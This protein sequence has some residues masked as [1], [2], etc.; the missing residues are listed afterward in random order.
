MGRL[1]S[2]IPLIQTFRG[3][4]MIG[5]LFLLWALMSI[6]AYFL[7]LAVERIRTQV[8][9]ERTSLER[10]IDAARVARYA[11][12][13]TRTKALTIDP[14]LYGRWEFLTRT[15]QNTC[16]ALS[17]PVR[18]WARDFDAVT[19]ETKLASSTASK[20]LAAASDLVIPLREDNVSIDAAARG[21]R[22]VAW[23]TVLFGV[24]G[25]I[26]L[27]S[28]NTGMLSQI[29]LE[30]GIVPANLRFLGLS[31]HFVFALLLTVVEAGIGFMHAVTKST[32][33]HRLSLS[34]VLAVVGGFAIA[35]V[36]GF[37]YSRI[38]AQ[39]E[40][41]DRLSRL[42]VFG[43]NFTSEEIFFLW[44]L[45]LVLTLFGFGSVVGG[46]ILTIARTKATSI[47]HVR[48]V[49]TAAA[50][51]A[52]SVERA[53]ERLIAYSAQW[54]NLDSPEAPPVC[55]QAAQNIRDLLARSPEWAS[56]ETVRLGSHDVTAL[57]VR[58]SVCLG[59]AAGASLLMALV[60]SVL[61][62]SAVPA[63]SRLVSWAA[64]FGL[65]AACVAVGFLLR[66][67]DAFEFTGHGRVLKEHSMSTLAVLIVVGALILGWG[68]YGVV[69]GWL[70]VR[71][72][73]LG[74]A[75]IGLGLTLVLT[76]REV[77]ALAPFV[78]LEVTR[79]TNLLL[80]LAGRLALL[81]MSLAA[82]LLALFSAVM[83]LVAAPTVFVASRLARH[84]RAPSAA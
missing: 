65:G 59:L 51:T 24:P 80:T 44:G 54:G 25:V 47:R 22:S 48:S 2:M 8:S 74:L 61:Y 79:F 23:V 68:S 55:V 21:K 70:G 20:L 67:R 53:G 18:E 38:G 82:A 10:A 75:V 33:P 64:G 58:T 69:A 27:I 56:V 76:C 42:T 78:L 4:L 13:E 15:W 35:C 5:L 6:P 14:P 84:E 29:L 50:V 37:F 28:V 57:G 72:A 40:I 45:L 83:Q 77:A 62:R 12:I 52:S 11:G 32:D 39:S 7:L 3:W 73:M 26:G 71:S 9:Q 41:S 31:L 81:C 19:R 43:A 1:G 30:L 63:S 16:L 17:A 34:S 66:P 60:F 36:E 46:A 49:Q